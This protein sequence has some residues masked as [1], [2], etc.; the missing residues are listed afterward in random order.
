MLRTLL[1]QLDAPVIVA[2]M[3]LVSS[4]ALVLAVCAEG[5]IGSFPAHSTRTRE[6]FRD[7]LIEIESGLEA[8]RARTGSGPVAPFA[9]NL[10]THATN[11]RMEG[12]LELC[13]EHKV[14]IVLTSKGQPTSAVERIHAYGGVV[15]HDVANRRHAEKAIAAGVDGLIVVTQGAGGHTG[16]INPFALMNEI[17]A[18]Y[19]GPIALSGCI[20]TGSNVLAAQAMGADAAYIGTRFIASVESIAPLA[21]KEMIIDAAATDIFF[22]SSVD[23][24]PAN[25]LTQSLLNAGADLDVLRTTLPGK[26]VALSQANKRWKDIWSAGQ[27]VGATTG[28]E[29]ATQIARRIKAEYRAA[30]DDM[31]RRL[32]GIAP[33]VGAGAPGQ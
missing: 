4:P 30:V 16:T 1:S 3:F 7:W 9:V 26:V 14:P 13:I 24:A 5:M 25:F 28:I 17:R 15:L 11:P 20:G 10:V 2:P 22:T 21:H 19:D 29:S 27:G 32:A 8:L 31:R 23:G 18:I 33:S 6:D 12:D